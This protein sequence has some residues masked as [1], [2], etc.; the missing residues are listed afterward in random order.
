MIIMSDIFGRIRS[1]ADKVAKGADKFAHIK[2]IEMDIGSIRKQVEDQYKKLGELTYKSRV[3]NEQES[4]EVAGII[5]KITE[6][7]QQIS[8]KEEEIK[9]LNSDESLPQAEPASVKKFCPSCGTE[10]DV[11]SNFCTRCGTKIG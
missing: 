5:T 9:R 7:H 6:L 11:G 4:P 10:N 3:A 1:G 8:V 2:R